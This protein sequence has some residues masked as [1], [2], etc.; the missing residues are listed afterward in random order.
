MLCEAANLIFVDITH[1]I[2]PYDIVAAAYALRHAYRSFP[3]GSVHVVAVDNH[4]Q[5]QTE[6]IIAQHEGHFFVAPDNGVL[7]LIFDGLPSDAAFRLP[8]PALPSA[9][10]LKDVFAKTVGYLFKNKSLSEIGAP[11]HDLIL[12][13]T[14]QPVVTNTFIRGSVIHIDNYEN[15]VI[16]I[17]KKMFEQ[18]VQNKPFELYFKR[19]YP[20]TQLSESYHDVAIGEP[21]CI[22]NAAGLLE[23]AVNMGMAASLLSLSLDDTVQ[24]I[25]E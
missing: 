21:L 17:S 8:F 20:I 10:P 22:F 15:V 5:R 18:A 1:H 6:Y 25:F 16:N 11:A 13:I 19:N 14:L 23:I 7:T 2:K 12:R 24:I 9:F 3:E 4:Y